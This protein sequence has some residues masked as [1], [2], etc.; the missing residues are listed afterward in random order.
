MRSWRPFGLSRLGML[1]HIMPFCCGSVVCMIDVVYIVE[2][3]EVSETL[4]Q[5][6]HINYEYS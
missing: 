3:K 4:Q 6:Y 2:K 5:Q 1:Q